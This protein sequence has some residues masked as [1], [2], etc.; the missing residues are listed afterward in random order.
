M[1]R[2]RHCTRSV[3]I[4]SDSIDECKNWL[5]SHDLNPGV[6]YLTWYSRTSLKMGGLTYGFITRVPNEIWI[7]F[8]L[9]WRYG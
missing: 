1:L 9:R 5:R 6:D 3:L 4:H 7:E 8:C 2:P